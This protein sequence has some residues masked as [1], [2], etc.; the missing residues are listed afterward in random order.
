ML[1]VIWGHL[2]LGGSTNQMAYA[3]HI[4]MFFFLSGMMFRREK[5]RNFGHFCRRRAKTLL[6]PYAVFSAVTWLYWVVR[7]AVLHLEVK[8][9]FMPLLQTVIAQGS[10]GYLVH[11][12][13]LWFVTCL[14]VVEMLYY[15]LSK[16][17]PWATA[18]ACIL[19]GVAGY[20]LVQPNDFF[21]FKL[22]PWN[23]EG[24]LTGMV[25]YGAGNLFTGKVSHH[26]VRSRI[27][28]HKWCSFFVSLALF[29]LVWLGGR[30]NGHVTIGQGFLGENIWLFY[31]NAF[32]GTCATL[33]FSVL[34]AELKRGWYSKPVAFLK[35]LGRNSFY[36]MAIH[37]PVMVDIVWLM[38]KFCGV[39]AEALR[40]SYPYTIPAFV[41]IVLLTALW[42]WFIRRIG[43]KAK[44]VAG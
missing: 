19:C 39:S 32:T 11:N 10:G 12:V 13:A 40:Y 31:L 9:W 34:L 21:D 17:P 27:L 4:P 42:I 44:H 37:V 41:A 28:R 35:W 36:A 7:S 23:M 43:C 20:W 18:A 16:L 25:F 3:F 15:F 1:A 29:L 8:S 33:I 14:F 30:V 22:L 26:T 24:A 38:S 2:M 6:L 5:Y